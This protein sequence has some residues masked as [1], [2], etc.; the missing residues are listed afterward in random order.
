[1]YSV[2]FVRFLGYIVWSG[3]LRSSGVQG[4]RILVQSD[5]SP[6]YVEGRIEAFLHGMDVSVLSP[7]HKLL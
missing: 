5:R 2:L 4:Y 7:V 3:P 6:Q 1:M